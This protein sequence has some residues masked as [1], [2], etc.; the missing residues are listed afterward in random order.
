MEKGIEILQ[1]P[2]FAV[3]FNFSFL[4]VHGVIKKLS[5]TNI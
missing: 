1:A 4:L 5:K 3:N 2:V